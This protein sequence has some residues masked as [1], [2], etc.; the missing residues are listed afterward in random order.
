MYGLTLKEHLATLQVPDCQE[1]QKPQ[2]KPE[3]KC[4][5][6]I[7]PFLKLK[8]ETAN[9]QGIELR[10]LPNSIF[11]DVPVIPAHILPVIGIPQFEEGHQRQA[12]EEK[13]P[14]EP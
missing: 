8:F 5:K 1:K 7:L 12:I 6:D 13:A 14:V 10:F 3:K 4:L 9:R 11:A 2:A